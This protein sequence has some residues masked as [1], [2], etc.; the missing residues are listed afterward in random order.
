V[1]FL[2]HPPIRRGSG[3]SQK[4]FSSL[5]EDVREMFTINT[6]AGEKIRVPHLLGATMCSWL[7][8]RVNIV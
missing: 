4:L 8:V 1:R 6:E 5:S 2:E 3:G 7:V